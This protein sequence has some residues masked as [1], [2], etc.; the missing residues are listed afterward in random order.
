MNR[1]G[2]LLH[3]AMT[4]AAAIKD[5]ILYRL[6]VRPSDEVRD[7]IKQYDDIV[8]DIAAAISEINEDEKE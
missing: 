4:S 5:L 3:A 6:A 7:L 2:Y 8:E 1:Y